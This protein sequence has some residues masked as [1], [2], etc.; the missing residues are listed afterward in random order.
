[1]SDKKAA[2]PLPRSE[3]RAAPRGSQGTSL[4]LA[5]GRRVKARIIE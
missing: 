2:N 4:C 5:R 3:V 1:M